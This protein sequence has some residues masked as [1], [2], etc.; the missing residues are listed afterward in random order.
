MERIDK[1]RA[2]GDEA[3]HVGC[4]EVRMAP[5]MDFV[6]AEIV[7]QNHD[8]VGA[9]AARFAGWQRRFRSPPASG[10]GEDESEDHSWPRVPG[11]IGDRASLA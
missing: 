11:E 2:F 3:V 6:E 9:L 4:L 7:H 1:Q 10:D 8:N 5:G